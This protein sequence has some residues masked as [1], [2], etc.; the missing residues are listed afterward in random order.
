MA[1]NEGGKLQ[2]HPKATFDIL[3]AKYKEGRAGV[4]TM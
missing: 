2:C 3:L 4:R 1:K